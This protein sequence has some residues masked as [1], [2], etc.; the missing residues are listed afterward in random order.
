MLIQLLFPDIIHRPV[1]FITHNVS[2]T[3]YCL[4]LQ[5]EPPQL[6]PIDTASPH[7]RVRRYRLAL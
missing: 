3:G 6:G 4:C 7:I 1:L 2:Q 5:V